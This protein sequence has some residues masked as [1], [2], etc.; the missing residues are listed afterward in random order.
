MTDTHAMDLNTAE[1][2]T[3]TSQP[4]H[5][6][7]PQT[8]P[9]KNRGGGCRTVPLVTYARGATTLLNGTTLFDPGASIAHHRHNVVESVIVV[10]GEAIVDI[11][12]RRTRLTTLDT[13][14]VP[15]GVDHH[16]ENAS[17]TEPMRI[18]WT[19]ASVDA[20]RTIAETGEHGRIDGERGQDSGAAGEHND[21]TES[22]APTAATA[23]V[24]VVTLVAAQGQ[25]DAL[26]AAVQ[27]AIPLFQAAK[28]ART[29]ELRRQ[30]EDPD[31]F[32][33]SIRWET[34]EDHTEGFRDS[35]AFGQWRELVMPHLAQAPRATHYRHVATGF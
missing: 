21:S 5:V 14:V 27:K 29:F 9:S 22:T 23:V 33:L 6:L 31:V 32:A 12:G 35:A 11:D 24:E 25:A 30:V 26:A 8:L 1:T 15:A 3:G 13:T 2:V 18:F 10:Q 34:I 7:H 19:Y 17:D 28:G 20:T 16:F 4:C